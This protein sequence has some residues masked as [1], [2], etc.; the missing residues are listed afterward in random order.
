MKLYFLV[1]LFPL[2]LSAQETSGSPERQNPQDTIQRR[3]LLINKIFKSDSIC[4]AL[5]FAGCFDG[6]A[7]QYH[8]VKQKQSYRVTYIS[9]QKV[10]SKRKAIPLKTYK[11]L[12]KICIQGL[13]IEEGRCSNVETIIISDKNNR[14][15]FTDRRCNGADNYIKKINDLLK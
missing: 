10:K 7:T 14:T 4:I 8:I 12:E 15:Y 9:D 2:C 5:K 1:L 3:T 6:N 11:K 13:S